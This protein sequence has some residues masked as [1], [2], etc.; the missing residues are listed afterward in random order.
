MHTHKDY[1][2]KK[3]NLKIDENNLNIKYIPVQEVLLEFSVL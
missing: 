2:S 1:K 3:R